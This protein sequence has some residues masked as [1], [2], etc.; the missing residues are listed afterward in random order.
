MKTT[1]RKVE[2]SDGIYQ[3][4]EGNHLLGR[5]G[6]CYTSQVPR[7]YAWLVFPAWETEKPDGRVAHDTRE[8]AR[9]ALV[10][11]YLDHAYND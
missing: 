3:V 11:A 8:D 4:F 2:N 5:V 10:M 7:G 6:K 1:Y 9:Y